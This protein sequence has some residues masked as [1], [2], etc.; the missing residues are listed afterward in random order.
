M[1]LPLVISAACV[2]SLSGF[3]MFERS[4]IKYKIDHIQY[5][6]GQPC[7]GMSRMMVNMTIPVMERAL[8]T[9]M[10][11]H[12]LY[13]DSRDAFFCSPLEEVMD[14]YQR[15]GSPPAITAASVNSWPL[16]QLEHFYPDT[17]TDYRYPQSGGWLGT[18]ECML[19]VMR[20][21]SKYTSIV[22]D[23]A[24]IW[25]LFYAAGWWRPM[26]DS[27]CEI[28]QVH[29]QT[30]SSEESMASLTIRNGRLYN[31]HTGSYPSIVH[32][33]GGYSDPVYGKWPDMIDMWSKV[34]PDLDQRSLAWESTKTS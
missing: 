29:G 27:H 23:E 25:Q 8:G 11:S 31:T 5:G 9:G 6:L 2:D 10:Y 3:E 34:H 7:P 15:L 1:K 17:G 26:I 18:I 20:H 24:A 32:F 19:R 13:T 16:P 28:F 21:M 30:F 12:V 33:S 14:K 22:E 4:C